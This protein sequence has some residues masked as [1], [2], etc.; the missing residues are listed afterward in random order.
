MPGKETKILFDSDPI[1]H[2]GKGK[3]L[4]ADFTAF[5]LQILQSDQIRVSLYK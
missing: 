1:T 4:A 5:L 3:G 2:V